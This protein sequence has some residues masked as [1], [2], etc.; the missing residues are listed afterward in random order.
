MKLL[1]DGCGRVEEVILM[2]DNMMQFQCG[3]VS[4]TTVEDLR[5]LFRQYGGER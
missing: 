4:E 2:S 5:E 1:C 3:E